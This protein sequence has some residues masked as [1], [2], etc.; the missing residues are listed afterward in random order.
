MTE[1]LSQAEIESAVAR[2]IGPGQPFEVVDTFVDGVNLKVFKYAPQNLNTLYRSS[3]EYGQRDFYVYENE[4][5]TFEAV[6]EQAVKVANS[7]IRLA[8]SLVS[9]D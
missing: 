1:V 6:W 9:P 3:L 8:L 4:R 7:L 5:Y 2:V